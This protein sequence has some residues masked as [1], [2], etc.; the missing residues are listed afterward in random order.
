VWAEHAPVGCDEVYVAK[1]RAIE[2]NDSLPAYL[3]HRLDYSGV[4]DDEKLSKIVEEREEKD[5]KNQDPVMN[6]LGSPAELLCV[7]LVLKVNAVRAPPCN[8]VGD[9][10]PD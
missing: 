8:G 10:Q 7:T 3:L 4:W 1:G 9:H 5:I 2:G 6:V